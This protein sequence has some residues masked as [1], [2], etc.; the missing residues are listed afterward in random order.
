MFLQKKKNRLHH[1]YSDIN[2]FGLI[3]I[4]LHNRTAHYIIELTKDDRENS[5]HIELLVPSVH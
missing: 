5:P 2:V 1:V 3:T 4:K